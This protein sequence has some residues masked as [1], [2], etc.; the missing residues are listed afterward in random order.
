MIDTTGS[1]NIGPCQMPGCR[2][3][4]GNARLT[5]DVICE[6][7]R[8]HYRTAIDRLTLHYVLLRVTLPKPV[9]PPG[10]RIMRVAAKVY[11]HPSEWASDSAR[12]IA[13]QLNEAHDALAEHLGHDPAPHPGSREYGRVAH[14]HHY[15]TCWFDQLCTWPAAGDTAEALVD[16]DRQV[17]QGLGKTNPRRF[18]PVPC[19]ACELLGLVRTD[20]GDGGEDRVDCHSCGETIPA[21]RYG[22]WTRTLLDEHLDEAS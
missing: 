9:P 22:W 1:G 7:S 6:P 12:A 20:G 13:D 14:A 18:L 4:D 5:R 3:V 2:D 10:E 8:R 11:G 19:P 21:E 16:L 15:L 17:R